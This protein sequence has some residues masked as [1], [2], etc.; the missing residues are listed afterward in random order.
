[1][2]SQI[3]RFFV[4][5]MNEDITNTKSLAQTSPQK[6]KKK[7]NCDAPTKTPFLFPNIR[8]W[9]CPFGILFDFLSVLSRESYCR[10]EW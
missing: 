5:K 6:K 9:I 4:R 3:D 2:D 10:A 7:K 1:M 8:D